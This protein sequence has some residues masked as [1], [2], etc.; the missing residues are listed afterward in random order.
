MSYSLE[1]FRFHVDTSAAAAAVTGPEA[2]DKWAP[3]NSLEHN[4]SSS[5]WQLYGKK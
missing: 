4:K 2:L 1:K 5:D 3:L